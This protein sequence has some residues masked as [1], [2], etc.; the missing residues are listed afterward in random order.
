MALAL[1]VAAVAPDLVHAQV[2]MGAV[3]ESD[4]G[5]RAAHLLH[6]DHV[7]EVAHPRPAQ[8]LLDGDPVQPERAECFPEIARELVGRVDL[9]CA[10]RDLRL[11][12]AVDGLPER[13]D[14]VAEGEAHAS[15]EHRR[16]LGRFMVAA[17][18]P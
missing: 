18:E 5:R 10:R 2:R 4:R 15:V 1:R 13:L 16:I 11:R 6:R 12:E 17:W 14:L 9:A 7:G 3:G 8:R